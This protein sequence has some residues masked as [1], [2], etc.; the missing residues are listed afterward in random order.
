MWVASAGVNLVRLVYLYEEKIR[1]NLE[2][3]QMDARFSGIN[4]A[5]G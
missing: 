5:L 3:N 2:R 1:R 4:P